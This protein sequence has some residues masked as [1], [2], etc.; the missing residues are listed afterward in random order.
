MEY[1]DRLK[2]QGR[3][4]TAKVYKESISNVLKL[5][6]KKDLDFQDVSVSLLLKF[7][8]ELLRSGVSENSISVYMRAIRAIFNRGVTEGVVRNVENPFK[9]YKVSKL[10]NRTVKRALT[11]AQIKS[12]IDLKTETNSSWSLQ[13]TFFYSATIIVG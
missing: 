5:L 8:S 6:K 4:K 12:I 9:V 7:E 2:Q 11:K 1:C 3:I 10:D 13:R